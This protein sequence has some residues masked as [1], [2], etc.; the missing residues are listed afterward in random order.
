[1]D[2]LAVLIRVNLRRLSPIVLDDGA[3]L[4]QI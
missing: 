2:V 3:N 1:M 4:L